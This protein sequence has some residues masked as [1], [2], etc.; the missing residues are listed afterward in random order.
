MQTHTCE[1]YTIQY[2][3]MNIELSERDMNI[4]KLNNVIENRKKLL[5]EIYK[6][7]RN[8]TEENRYLKGVVR[9][10]TNYYAY[11]KKQKE[12]QL[13]SLYKLEFYINNVLHKNANKEHI[14]RQSQEDKKSVEREIKKVKREMN[15]LQ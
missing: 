8:S 1:Y 15:E 14:L 6:G 9:D 7:I 5:R 12:K 4:Q 3:V 2:I 11:M 10:Y 13:E